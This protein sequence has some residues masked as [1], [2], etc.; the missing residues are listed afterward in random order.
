MD[1]RIKF[2]EEYFPFDRIGLR[3]FNEFICRRFCMGL[4]LHPEN[5]TLEISGSFLISWD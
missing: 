2:V 4:L 5:K 3:S 1:P